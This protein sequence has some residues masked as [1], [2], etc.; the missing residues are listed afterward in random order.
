MKLTTLNVVSPVASISLL[1]GSDVHH[2]VFTV[3]V[4]A[5]YGLLIVQNI[6]TD[7]FNGYFELSYRQK[8]IWNKTCRGELKPIQ[9]IKNL[10]SDKMDHTMMF[11]LQYYTLRILD[12]TLF[13]LH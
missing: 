3:W 13:Y 2:F 10:F 6:S 1:I 11:H 7:K 8:I 12:Y 9:I 4:H 5:P